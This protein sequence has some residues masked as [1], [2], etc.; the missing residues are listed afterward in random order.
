MPFC[1]KC[2]RYLSQDS[3]S[4]TECGTST[5]AAMINIKKITKKA[6]AN[7]VAKVVVNP[8]VAKAMIPYENPILVKQV[9]SPGAAKTTALAKAIKVAVPAKTVVSTKTVHPAKPV[10]PA[11]PVAVVVYPSHEIMKSNVSLKE[12]IL[13][14][15]QDY[16]TQ[17][18]DFNLKCPNDHL[19]SAGKALPV[20]N[21]KAYCLKCGERLMKPT[22]KK[23]RRRH[24]F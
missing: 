6:S 8:K 22:R 4:C 7:H 17:T 20:S 13:A 5:T 14:N 9:V 10:V 18:F 2:G 23:I 24:R 11:K 1:R 16:E 12:D 21:G 19:W 3:E 15:P